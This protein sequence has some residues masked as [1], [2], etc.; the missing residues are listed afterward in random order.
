MREYGRWCRMGL[1]VLA[2]VAMAL[3]PVVA[4]AEQPLGKS[5][6]LRFSANEVQFENIDGFERMFVPGLEVIARPGEPSLPWRVV[7]VL[8]PG[9]WQRVSVKSE[10][11]GYRDLGEGHRVL[12]RQKPQVL[13]FGRNRSEAGPLEEGKAA[14]YESSEAFPSDAV[15]IIR[16]KPLRDATLVTAV[17]C[18]FRYWPKSGRLEMAAGVTLRFTGVQRAEW[19]AQAQRGLVA[20]EGARLLADFDFTAEGNER[21]AASARD[22]PIAQYVVVTSG[23]FVPT[24]EPLVRWKNE[25][26]ITAKVV[27]V[28][29]IYRNFSG[30]DHQ[31]QVREFLKFA[32][33]EWGTRWVLL[34]GDVWT[35]P[36]R[37]AFAMDCEANYAENENNIP[38]DLYFSDLDGDWNANGNAVFGEVDDQVDGFPDVYVGRAP[39]QTYDEV[40]TFVWKDSVYERAPDP[41]TV[42]KMLFLGEVLWNNPYTDS[43]EGK[44]LIDLLYVPDR[45]DPITKLYE[46][47]GNE[48]VE[49]V[50]EALNSG[51]NFVNHDGHAWYTVMGV[52]QGYLRRSDVQGLT[53]GGRLPLIYSI[54]CWPAAFDH[55]CI[56]EDFLNNPNGGAVAFIGNSRYGWGSPGNPHFGYS[57]RFDQQFY[58]FVFQEGVQEVGRALAL[59][60]A[61]YMPFARQEN[62]Y[63]WCEYEINLLGD[64]ELPLWTDVPAE[65]SVQHPDTI[66]TGATS[67]EV[68][69]TANG[70]PC[71]GA[72]VAISQDGRLRG[73]ALTDA[74]GFASVPV[75]SLEAGL[76]GKVVVTGQNLLPHESGIVVTSAQAYL[77]VAA[78]KIEDQFPDELLN[79]GTTSELWFLVWN[80]GGTGSAGGMATLT[81]KAVWLEV[82]TASVDV[83]ELTPGDSTWVGPFTV[84][85]ADTVQDGASAP[86]KLELPGR[87]VELAVSVGWPR[88][89][90]HLIRIATK[91]HRINPGESG[92]FVFGLSNLGSGAACGIQVRFRSLAEGL[93][94]EEGPLSCGE[95]VCLES[96]AT[97]SLSVAATVDASAPSPWFPTVEVTIAANDGRYSAR[98]TVQV[99]VGRTGFVDSCSSLARWDEPLSQL[100]TLAWQLTDARFYSAPTAFYCG[101]GRTHEY[102]AGM[103]DSLVTL[104][105]TVGQ[106]AQ[107]TFWCWYDVAIYGVDG[108]Y[109]RVL[110]PDG[111]WKTL[112]FIGSGGALPGKLM[113]NDWLPYRYDLG[114]L[115]PG[116]QTRLCFKFVSDGDTQAE[117]VYIDDVEVTSAVEL[118]MI[119]A[120]DHARKGELPARFELSAPYP[121]PFNSSVRLT[122]TLPKR[123][124]VRLVVYDMLGRRVASL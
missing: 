109:V 7:N 56:A 75:D 77:A 85:T 54:G 105:F 90:A 48:S 23:S 121:N 87:T 68:M 93:Q 103:A 63:R 10:V 78:K 58:R 62:V 96:G 31:E 123:S 72:R 94:V 40:R 70:Q 122:F 110:L 39:V 25:K 64:P 13:S 9:E 74:A 112:D 82:Q 18:P 11:D 102:V 30:F 43:G 1:V 12:P 35:V 88:L 49:S 95:G 37:Y 84:V 114:F 55:E 45:F 15:R 38:C 104:P 8:V 34:G 57:D 118:G 117:G 51:Y 73:V 116:T 98:D 119:N 100:D 42:L 79:P 3:A 29:W 83:G 22:L 19:T 99:T 113:G 86:L 91:E 107:L 71:S 67:V 46:S 14:I 111:T 108:L 52:G 115:P 76:P 20:K 53:N 32:H 2:L 89:H 26:G 97:T 66:P 24:F 124:K 44:N 47:L 81:S 36:M 59:A 27:S 16:T 92:E 120:V 50:V 65:L 4:H 41:Q 21:K 61:Y 6:E 80:A 33:R 28:E 69:V 5:V 60:K 17:V 101:N 106:D